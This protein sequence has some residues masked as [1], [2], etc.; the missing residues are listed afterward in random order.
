MKNKNKKYNIKKIY[1]IGDMINNT[2]PANVNKSYYEYLKN[3][4][5]ICNSNNKLKRIIHFI[6]KIMFVDYVVISGFSKLNYSLL[7]I[8]KILKKKTFYLM[9]GYL[10]EEAKYNKIITEQKINI[11]KKIIEKTSKIICVSKHFC[12]MIQQDFPQYK[13]KIKYVNNG[14]NKLNSTNKLQ[15]YNKNKDF[16]IITTGGGKKRKNNL[17][18]CKAIEKIKNHQIKFIVIGELE[19]E[20]EKIKSYKFVE[21]Y[22]ELSHDKVLELMTTANLYI[23]NSLFETFGLGVVEGFQCNCDILISKNVGASCIF[24]NLQERDI[25]NSPNNIEEIYNKIIEKIKKRSSIKCNYELA[26]W[27]T[28]SKTLLNLIYNEGKKKSEK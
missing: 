27:E 3:D 23:Q 16:V 18:I 17:S 25:I 24:E 28:S 2:G 26:T 20:G 21:Y 15:D 5:Y 6:S 12:E 19:Q 1:W 14:I 13:F 8:S 11:E 22:E 9:H 10:K 4:I 7:L